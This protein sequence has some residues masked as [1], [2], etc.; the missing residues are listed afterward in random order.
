MLADAAWG[1]MDKDFPPEVG[2]GV[3]VP[4]PLD[5]LVA[6]AERQLAAEA[7]A[8]AAGGVAPPVEPEWPAEYAAVHSTLHYLR[9]TLALAQGIEVGAAGQLQ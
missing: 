1:K 7:A 8:A 9:A 3:E 4:N 2:E 5:G 6:A